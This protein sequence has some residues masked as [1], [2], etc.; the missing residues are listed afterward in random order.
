[1]R[2]FL[3]LLVLAACTT[4]EKRLYQGEL[5]PD[6]TGFLVTGT[7]DLQ[8]SFGRATPG[9]IAAMIRVKGAPATTTGTECQ[10]LT[11][12]DG[13]QAHFDAAFV[14]WRTQTAGAGR[15]CG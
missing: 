6:S 3:A 15:F 14:G 1:M 11:W 9:A 12:P 10:T 4:P 5:V 8:I 2:A 7:N 13:T